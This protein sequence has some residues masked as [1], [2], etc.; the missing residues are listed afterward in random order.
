MERIDRWTARNVANTLVDMLLR[1][2][3]DSAHRELIIKA[4]AAYHKTYMDNL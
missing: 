3:Y 1:H 4:L 2:N